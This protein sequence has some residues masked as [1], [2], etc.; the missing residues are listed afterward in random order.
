MRAGTAAEA[1][2]AAPP[3]R[4]PFYYGWLVLAV[5]AF[6]TFMTG[7]AQTYGVAVFVDPMLK[8]LG[9][10]RSVSAG[11]YSL[12][13]ILAGLSMIAVGRFFDRFS[14]RWVI[15]LLVVLYGLACFWM[16]AV[17]MPAM[18]LLGFI[19]LRFSGQASLGLACSTLAARWFVRRR[20]RAMSITVLGMALSNA[21]VPLVLTALITAVG[22]RSAWQITG[23]VMWATLL[24]PT[25]L[26]V[27]DRPEAIGLLPDGGPA[28]AAEA[29]TPAV[30]EH[31]WTV[32]QA[33]RSRTF[34]LLLFASLIPGTVMTGLFFHQVSY[35]TARGLSPE[36]A[37][38]IFTVYS[39]AFATMTLVV[40][41]V[42]ER[43]P[44][45]YV[46]IAGLL[47]LPVSVTL[48]LVMS[49]VLEAV[50]YAVLLGIVLGT[51]STTASVVWAAYYGRRHLGSI[52]GI[53]QAGV[54][55]AAATGPL[56]L[57]VPYDLTGSYA[58]GL[59]FM[60]ALPLLG[61][62]AAVLAGPPGPPPGPGAGHAPLRGGA[63]LRAGGGGMESGS[64]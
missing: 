8:E 51:N 60:A 62:L 9:W 45:R 15:A 36:T 49:S 26:I 4:V 2:T 14:A 31:T 42:L 24:L 40:G 39:L 46:L 23:L 35:F 13:S 53:T 55:V 50:L 64:R 43:A 12:A 21:V 17:A 56:M 28:P 11:A 18:L 22:W 1:A 27:R 44:E 47:L 3:L 54:V 16:A 32:S 48:L 52:R 63:G 20:G 10:S 59:W 34:W 61:A 57:S 25:L 30:V 58:P 5:A 33:I 7:P 38:T 29:M 37:A 19:A 6:G 41:F